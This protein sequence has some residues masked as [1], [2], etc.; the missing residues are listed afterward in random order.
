MLM[1]A[2]AYGLRRCGPVWVWWFELEAVTT[3]RGLVVSLTMLK[4][5]RYDIA[6]LRWCWLGDPAGVVPYTWRH[7]WFAKSTHACKRGEANITRLTT[8]VYTQIHSIILLYTRLS[9]WDEWSSKR[10]DSPV[11]SSY[12]QLIKAIRHEMRTQDAYSHYFYLR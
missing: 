10:E 12:A 4:G 5:R 1:T 3:Y 9:C 2:H 8:A 11:W 7:E 6:A